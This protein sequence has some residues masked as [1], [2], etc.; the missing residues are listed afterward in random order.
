LVFR[1]D[2]GEPEDGAEYPN[3][4]TQ[5]RLVFR[6]SEQ[7][8][9]IIIIIYNNNNDNKGWGAPMAATANE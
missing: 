9:I 1:V 4:S 8:I 2:A 6:E 3:D 5:D 7:I